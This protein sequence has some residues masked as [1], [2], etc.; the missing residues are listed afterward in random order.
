MEDYISKI[1]DSIKEEWKAYQK[2]LEQE[3]KELEK[4]YP[5]DVPN[6]ASNKAVVT[7]IFI[8]NSFNPS[9]GDV[10]EFFKLKNETIYIWTQAQNENSVLLVEVSEDVK[11]EKYWVTVA[12]L[13]DLARSI[14]TSFEHRI[15]DYEKSTYNWIYEFDP[16]INIENS[17][18]YGMNIGGPH[19]LDLMAFKSGVVLKAT[20]IAEM[21]DVI[22]LLSRDEKAYTATSALQSSFTLHPCCLICETGLVAYHD[23]IAQEPKIWDHISAIPNMEVAIV[24]AC[25]TVEAIVGQPPSKTPT[26]TYSYKEKWKRT[27]GFDPDSLFEKGAVSYLDFW[28]DLFY[29]YRNSSAHSYGDIHYDLLRKNTVGSQCFAADILYNYIKKNAIDKTLVLETLSFNQ[30]LLARVSDSFSTKLTNR[31]KA[32]T[33]E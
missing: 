8:E 17:T 28:Y 24:Q 23:H 7:G 21:A 20:D 9:V 22:E 14:Y 33:V 18:F 19:I 32:N 31:D 1:S 26:K 4:R 13:I 27:L 15:G 2:E 11:K 6:K 3:Q 12:K 29:E 16:K 5:L 25:R 10:V 30:D